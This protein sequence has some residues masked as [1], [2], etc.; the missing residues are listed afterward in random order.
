MLK[1]AGVGFEAH[2][3]RIDEEAVTDSLR[4]APVRDVADKLAELKAI[5]VSLGHRDAY[6][7]GSDSMLEI[8][9][10]D[11]VVALGGVAVQG[12][13]AHGDAGV[14]LDGGRNGAVQPAAHVGQHEPADHRR[15]LTGHEGAE[16][17]SQRPMVLWADA[18][19]AGG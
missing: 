11:H 17:L 2:P 4:G 6:V 9:R 13:T 3:A 12:V 8:E 14:A 15:A 10:G 18:A 19:H 1:A 5:K 16:V 7:L